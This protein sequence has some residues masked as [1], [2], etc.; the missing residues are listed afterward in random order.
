MVLH[1][2]YPV[3]AV[4]CSLDGPVQQVQMRHLK[5]GRGE[6]VQID[7][8][9]MVLRGD[10][11]AAGL[12]AADRMVA[13]AV[14]EF[15]LVGAGAVGQRKNLMPEA[16]AEERVSAPQRAHRVRFARRS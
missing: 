14:S 6:A 4:C 5:R 9:G 3:C 8:I 10:F 13:A 12:Q 15:Q 7:R 1:T 2:E 16:D 11:D